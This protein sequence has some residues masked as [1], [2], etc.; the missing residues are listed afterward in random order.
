MKNIAVIPARSGSKALRDKNIKQLNGKPLIAYSILTALKSG[1][2]D[3]VM[4]STDSFQYAQIARQYGATV[5][6]MRSKENSTDNAGS[7]D[8]V[9]EVLANYESGGRFFDTVCLLQPTSPLRQVGDIQDAYH[10]FY[11][12]ASVAVASVCQAGHPPAWYGQLGPSSSLDGF[13]QPEKTGNRQAFG[14]YYRLN[15]AIYI[16]NVR[17]LYEN[18]YLFREGSYAY[19][20]DEK[21]SVDIDTETDF[22]IAE[23]LMGGVFRHFINKRR[24]L[25]IT[26][27]S[28]GW[29][30]L[31]K[32]RYA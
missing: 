15:G 13:L 10:L 6:F 17:A 7:W 29:A 23:F 18:D 32:Q 1:L 31:Q 19:L 26:K 16:W 3:E 9:K 14:Q 8:V 24:K 2:F 20:M 25:K 12:R 30:Y 11:D 27:L 21:R 5:P 22:Q 28:A 4:V